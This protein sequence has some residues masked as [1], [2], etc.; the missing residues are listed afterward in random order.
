MLLQMLWALV[1]SVVLVRGVAPREL[2]SRPAV[3]AA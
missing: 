1:V 3:G 2:V